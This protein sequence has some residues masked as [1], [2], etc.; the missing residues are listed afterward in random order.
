GKLGDVTLQSGDTQAAFGFYQQSHEILVK[1]AAADPTAAQAQRDLSVSYEKLGDVTLQSGDT[2]AALRYYQQ[3][4]DIRQK[5]AVAD[6]TAAQAQR[7]LMISAL[8]IGDVLLADGEFT[9][10]LEQ[11]RPGIAILNR[12]IDDGKLVQQSTSDKEYLVGQ[13]KTCE[14]LQI[15]TGEWNVLLE[16]GGDELP[17]WLS[18]RCTWLA[19]KQRTADV[20]QA[21]AHLQTLE[22]VTADNLYNAACG[23]GM[24]L[25]LVS[26]WDGQSDFPPKA[27]I[28]EGTPE[29]QA[30]RKEYRAKA[31]AAFH[32]AVAQGYEN[33]DH[34]RKD[35]DLAALHGDAE[36]QALLKPTAAK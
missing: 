1:L 11:Y 17:N 31:L 20:A 4:L 19:K 3:G 15:A 36:F 5:L 29:E 14:N 35:A 24:C 25:K 32:A 16:A 27:G 2:Q 34:A 28:P 26:G 12:M 18:N 7:D 13:V 6:P 10:A 9:K 22:P 21:A 23:F 33:F 8:K 30:A